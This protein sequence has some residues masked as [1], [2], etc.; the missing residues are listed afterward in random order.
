[1]EKVNAVERVLRDFRSLRGVPREFWLALIIKMLEAYAYS[2]MALVFVLFLSKDLGMSDVNAGWAY[3]LWGML[4]GVYAMVCG[5]L[6]DRIGVKL[7]LLAGTIFLLA[8]R[9]LVTFSPSDTILFVAIFGLMPFGNALGIPVLAT[10]LKRYTTPKTRAFAFSL[11]YAMLNVGA[12][13]AF[14][15]VDYARG[16]WGE[17]GLVLNF[18]AFGSAHLT[19]YRAIFFTS[20]IATLLMMGVAVFV[21]EIRVSPDGVVG[22]FF[23]ERTLPD[24]VEAPALVRALKSLLIWPKS[25][26]RVAKEGKFWRFLLFIFLLLGVRYLLTHLNATFPKYFVREFGQDAPY[27]TVSAINSVMVIF[28]APLLAP[29]VNRLGIFRSILVGSVISAL[30]VFFLTVETT[31]LTV[32]CF[33]VAFSIGESIW[34]P[35]VNEYAATIAPEGR[36]G[37]YMS[38][39]TIP[40]FFAKMAVGGLSGWLLMNYCPENGPRNS[41]MMWFWIGLMALSSPILVYVFRRVIRK[42]ENV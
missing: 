42:D 32:V 34:S 35:R 19:V 33:M 24:A 38:L 22:R 31:Y 1:M 17:T 28:L 20:I 41:Q 2:S 9:V 3:G 37:S 18:G 40:M 6:V 16:Q 36:E 30:A 21:R 25:L 26:L 11:F 5:V 14:L 7:S 23:P 4:I 12:T 39:A 13:A 27:G 10:G 15:F 29:L 8:S